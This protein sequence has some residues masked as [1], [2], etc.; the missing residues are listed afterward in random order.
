MIDV[1]MN[2]FHTLFLTK[3]G[4]VYA[5][6]HGHGGRLGL[7][8]HTPLMK[9]YMIKSFATTTIKMVSVGVDHSLFLTESGQVGSK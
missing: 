9:P 4:H 7:S 2:K 8:V 3:S 5:C 1:A 6:G